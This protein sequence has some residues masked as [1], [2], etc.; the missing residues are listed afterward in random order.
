M[1]EDLHHHSGFEAFVYSELPDREQLL[2]QF[3]DSDLGGALILEQSNDIKR[4]RLLRAFNSPLKEFVSSDM[5]V[6]HEVDT[7]F[8]NHRVVQDGIQLFY[9]FF[10][11]VF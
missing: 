9:S 4:K 8:F 2:V 7:I 3:V 10:P 11:R 6:P 1:S 5:I